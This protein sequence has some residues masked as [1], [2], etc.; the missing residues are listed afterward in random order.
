MINNER[1]AQPLV[2]SLPEG[3]RCFRL[4]IVLNG[5]VS[6]GAWT[7]GALDGLIEVVGAWEAAKAAGEPGIP[8]HRIRV[9][10]LGGAS[11]GG[12]CA[13][14]FARAASPASPHDCGTR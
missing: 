11:G 5:T 8:D 3:E 6:A 2:P 14:I 13:A 10:V 1:L 7:A 9:E 12:V 4:G